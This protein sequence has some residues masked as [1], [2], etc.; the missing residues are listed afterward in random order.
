MDKKPLI[1]VSICAVV[2]LVLGSS[3]PALAKPQSS[4]PKTIISSI[5]TSSEDY[6]VYIG[7]GIN[8]EYGEGKFGLGW[9][10]TVENTGDTNINGFTYDKETTLLGKL[11]DNGSGPFSLLPGTGFSVGSWLLDF[12]PISFINLTVVVGNMTYSKSGYGIG[13]FVLMAS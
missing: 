2:L 3:V 6:K 11:V 4:L 13:P 5:S 7:A 1:G 9:H 8:R 10:M 12:H